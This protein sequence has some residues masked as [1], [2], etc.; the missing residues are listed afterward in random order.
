MMESVE[1]AIELYPWLDSVM[2]LLV[3][4]VTAF[5]AQIVFKRALLDAAERVLGQTSF[6][7]DGAATRSRVVRRLASILPAIIISA[8]IGLVRDLP[9]SV[10]SVITNVSHAFIVLTV[11]MTLAAVLDR[12][13]QLYHRRPE[14][15]SRSIRG[16]FQIATIAIY[17]VAA[18]LM[19]A[20]LI[21]RS[22]VILLSGLGA[23]AAV[24]ILVFQDTLLSFVASILISSGDMVRVGDWIEIPSLNADGDVV[25]ISLHTI[26]VQNFDKTITAIPIRKLV[27]DSFKNW[28]GMEEAGGRRIKRAIYL[29]QTSI[30]FLAP[31]AIE[32][33]SCFQHLEAYLLLKLEELRD[34]NE[35]LGETG[36]ISANTRRIT[37]SGTLRAYLTAYLRAHP[38]IRQDMTLLV[39]QLR[40]GP[41]GLPIEIYCFTNTTD[42][43]THETVQADIFDHVFALLPEFDLAVF[44]KP[45]GADL[46]N[47][48][49]REGPA[50]SAP[51]HRPTARA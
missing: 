32:K 2:M 1:S 27:T 19:T 22:P 28:R 13:D 18:I 21:D 26:R 15:H 23:M 51:A 39:R 42:W 29:D 47:W 3:L 5:V 40:P 6:G 35:R 31:E 14:T 34:W 12:A 45:S 20:I 16:Y 8:G 38:S 49:R 48:R 37:N 9:A 17:A 4:L 44:Q 41:E 30:G 11:A 25:D 43:S 24:L 7:R 46:R 33:L 50:S 36:R 10:V